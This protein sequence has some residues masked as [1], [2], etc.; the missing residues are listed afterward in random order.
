[1]TWPYQEKPIAGMSVPH[2]QDPSKGTTYSLCDI[3]DDNGAVRVAVVHGC[4]GLVTLLAGR[5][6]D[7]ELHRGVLIQRDGLCEEG[8]ANGGFSVGI[9]LIFDET[10]NNRTLP[11]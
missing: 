6:P 9:E 1:M 8:S 5:I 2:T 11:G 4:Q 10:K 7:L 3:V